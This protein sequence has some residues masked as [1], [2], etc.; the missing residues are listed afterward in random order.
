MGHGTAVLWPTAFLLFC[1]RHD[2]EEFGI[3][4]RGILGCVFLSARTVVYLTGRGCLCLA[5]AAEGDGAF[6]D[7]HHFAVGSVRVQ[8]DAAARRQYVVHNLHFAVVGKLCEERTFAALETVNV[9]F[10]NLVEIYN[11]NV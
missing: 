2:S 1:R 6:K 5:V 9:L 3:L 8:S 10:F 7:V 4:V 11:H